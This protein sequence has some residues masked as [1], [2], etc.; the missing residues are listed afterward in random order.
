[1]LGCGGAVRW[2]M[3]ALIGTSK[4]NQEP[5]AQLLAF[6]P[7][8]L[9]NPSRRDAPEQC[10]ETQEAD[11]ERHHTDAFHFARADALDRG[12]TGAAIDGALPDR[13]KT[14][15]ETSLFSA[16]PIRRTVPPVASARGFSLSGVETTSWNS[17]GFSGRH[18]REPINFHRSPDRDRIRPHS[19]LPGKCQARPASKSR[20]PRRRRVQ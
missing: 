1:M 9:E 20:F 4:L 11:C 17:R 8:A 5:V 16:L 14:R 18:W 6:R 7:A 15:R 2:R 12:I 10:Y 13:D 19:R 3:I